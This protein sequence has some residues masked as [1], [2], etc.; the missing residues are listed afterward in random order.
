MTGKRCAR[1]HASIGERQRPSCTSYSAICR[2]IFWPYGLIYLLIRLPRE[3]GDRWVLYAPCCSMP[4][5]EFSPKMAQQFDEATAISRRL[6]AWERLLELVDGRLIYRPLRHSASRRA[7]LLTPWRHALASQ[8]ASAA[9][10]ISA[11]MPRYQPPSLL[12]PVT[13]HLTFSFIHMRVHRLRYI[14]VSKFH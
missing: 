2:L 11:W 10:Q 13:S 7:S 5:K 6:P 14:T 3:K 4:P 9:A 1:Q 8:H 12:A